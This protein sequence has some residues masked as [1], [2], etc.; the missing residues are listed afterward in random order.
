MY[1]VQLIE[2]PAGIQVKLYSKPV[3]FDFEREV[4]KKREKDK[5]SVVDE[6]EQLSLDLDI[7]QPARFDWDNI[8]SVDFDEL[9]GFKTEESKR[10]AMT[11]AKNKIYYI[12]RS[13]VWEW[14]VTLTLD[15]KKI[16]RYDYGLLSRKVRKWLEHLRER[17]A[18]D[19]YYLI[20]PER[21]KD[22][23]WHFHALIGGSTGL[24]FVESGHF[25]ES[26]NTIYNFEN[27][28][29]GFSTATKVQDTARVSSYIAKYVTKSLVEETRGLHRFWASKN[30]QRAEVERYLVEGPDRAEYVQSLYEHMTWKKRLENEYNTVE[31]FELPKESGD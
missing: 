10:V 18:P 20:V 8:E 14:F 27:W 9:S 5:H 19:M 2:Y 22:G 6:C 21:H 1:N 7:F 31:Y 24:K 25:D 3:N 11:R 13:N 26:G 17:K 29:F 12:A 28:K 16:N 4:P 23:A 30:C 15:Q